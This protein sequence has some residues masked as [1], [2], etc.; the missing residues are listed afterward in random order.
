[1]RRWISPGLAT[2]EPVQLADKDYSIHLFVAAVSDRRMNS[3]AAAL[4][5]RRINATV[6]DRRYNFVLF[7]PPML[8]PSYR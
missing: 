6:R 5:E 3:S 8:D 7:L 4:Y 1:M 2:D